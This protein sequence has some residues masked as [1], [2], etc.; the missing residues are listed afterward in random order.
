M[1]R[2]SRLH[3]YPAMVADD[4]ASELAGRF[5]GPGVTVLDPFCGTARTLVAAAERGAT[6]FGMDVNP[7]AVLI[8]RAKL[9]NPD[10]RLIRSIGDDLGKKRLRL[11]D[12]LPTFQSSRVEWFPRNVRRE[13]AALCGWL[14]RQQISGDSL[15]LIAAVLSATAREVSYCR[16]DQWKLH[17]MPA[18]LRSAWKP[19]V[20]KTFRRRL[21]SIVAEATGEPL[22]GS[23]QIL[24]GD[25]RHLKAALDAQRA[26]PAIDVTITS[27]PYGDSRTTLNYGGI[28]AL[29]LGVVGH[30]QGLRVGPLSSAEID[31]Q[32]LGGRL[33]D[34]DIGGLR[35]F[36]AGRNESLAARRVRSYLADLTDVCNQIGAVSGSRSEAIFVVSRRRV[37]GHRLFL[38]RYVEQEMRR[39]DFGLQSVAIRRIHQKVTPP[40]VH[41]VAGS[42]LIN[43]MREE[44]VLHFRR[45]S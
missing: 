23:R 16:K 6:I 17:R 37:Q 26:T 35:S 9:G 28:S 20:Y 4:L 21:K 45:G 22:T 32:G 13:L 2:L 29:C 34:A 3:P 5:A 18:R 36:W 15:L 1:T 44:H 38:D 12:E 11:G 24:V 10:W 31:A 42:R 25:A 7:L 8:A 30:L 43:T 41:W 33:G 19:S 40:R 14:N 39:Q 27:P